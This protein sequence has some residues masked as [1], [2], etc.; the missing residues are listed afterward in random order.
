MLIQNG[1][2]SESSVA[3]WLREDCKHETVRESKT[4]EGDHCP[5]GSREQLGSCPGVSQEESVERFWWGHGTH[6]SV[7]RVVLPLYGGWWRL[8]VGSSREDSGVGISQHWSWML[9]CP[10][11][12]HPLSPL[13]A[14]A[15]AWHSPH[16]SSFSSLV[17][18]E[19][20]QAPGRMQGDADMMES[21]KKEN[22]LLHAQRY[23]GPLQHRL[24]LSLYK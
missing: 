23:K 10:E 16:F 20:L 5:L 4:R 7:P 14:A 15:P 3:L 21:L 2:C 19:E 18:A 1:F 17:F 13:L 9:Y 8:S 12:R 6:A 24:T 22:E 11:P